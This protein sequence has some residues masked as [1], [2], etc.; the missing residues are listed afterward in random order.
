MKYNKAGKRNIITYLDSKSPISEAF[1]TLRTNIQFASVDKEIKTIMITSSGPSEGKST[2]AANL[3]VV[4]A[5][6]G[7]KTL[8]VDADMRKPTVHHTFH[9]LNREGLTTALSGQKEVNQ[10]VK[11]TEIEN[12][13]I[14]SSGPI[15]P[16]PA[17]LLGSKS[18]SRQIEEISTQYDIVLFDTP[19]IIAVADA[20]ILASQL[21]GVLLVINSGK[22]NQDMAVKAKVLLDNVKAKILGCVLNNRKIQGENYYYYY[23]GNN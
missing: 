3:A 2:I 8:L 6:V 17:E 12:L 14:L 21:D 10:L 11:K 1:R 23:Y 20:Q 16:N 22:T 5:Q 19:P 15:P 13:D 7:K 9:I 4:M 18:M